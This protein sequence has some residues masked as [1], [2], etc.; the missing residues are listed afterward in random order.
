MHRYVEDWAEAQGLEVEGWFGSGEFGEAYLT[1]CGKIIKITS[2]IKEFSAAYNLQGTKSD[3]LVDIY[4]AELTEDDHLFILMQAVDTDGIDDIFSQALD[5]VQEYAFGEWEY[6][7][8]DEL[9]DDFVCDDNV[10]AMIDEISTSIFELKQ[11]GID[12]PDVHDGNIG[13]K[14]GRYVLFDF[15]MTEERQ[16]EDFKRS[17]R[18]QQDKKRVS[19]PAKVPTDSFGL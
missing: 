19:I 6:F 5:V 11:R 10:L 13:M 15:R 1:S 16:Y 12:L 14:N 7:D 17:I 3:Y 4:K 8:P 2:D 18:D 9:P